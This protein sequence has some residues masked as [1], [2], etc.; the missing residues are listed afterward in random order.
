TENPCVDG[1]IPPLATI[2]LSD[3][4]NR[5]CIF[6]EMDSAR[7]IAREGSC[8]AVYDG[9]P[10]SEGHILII[11]ERHIASFRELTEDEW[12]SVH[13]LAKKLS[14]RLLEQDKTIDGFNLG[15]NDGK[16]AG[17]TIFHAHVHLIPRRKNDVENPRGGVR[18]VIPCK[19]CYPANTEPER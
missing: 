18:H 15:I 9:F 10:V 2:F 16:A 4:K 7:V 8:Y 13:K 11:P 12:L 5:S 3:M 17:Q 1:S 14:A 19:G 6:C